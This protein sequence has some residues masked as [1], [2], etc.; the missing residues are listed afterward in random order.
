M[1]IQSTS[2]HRSTAQVGLSLARLPGWLIWG[3]TRLEQRST[4]HEGEEAR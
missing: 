3:L 2:L 4:A 1:A